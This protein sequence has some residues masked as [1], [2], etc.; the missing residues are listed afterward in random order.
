MT[1][2]WYETLR[3]QCE[4]G[5][6]AVTEALSL[7]E[8]LDKMVSLYLGRPP[9]FTNL[10]EIE[11]S[12]DLFF[13]SPTR[14]NSWELIRRYGL[15]TDRDD[16]EISHGKISD[17]RSET[18]RKFRIDPTKTMGSWFNSG[19]GKLWVTRIT[20]LDKDLNWFEEH[21]PWALPENYLVGQAASFF[22]SVSP[23]TRV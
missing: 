14:R 15:P 16:G 18:D 11:W 10:N 3:D 13:I 7:R 9:E 5:Q 17:G 23:K 22:R 2:D 4:T 8:V 1:K 21:M 20:N 6:Q 12:D 19:T